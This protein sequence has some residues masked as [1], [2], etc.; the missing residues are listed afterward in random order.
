VFA[1]LAVYRLWFTS[2]KAEGYGIQEDIPEGYR[3]YTG[4]AASKLSRSDTSRAKNHDNH[5]NFDFLINLE[6]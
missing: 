1:S 4:M 3:V 6:N 2:A 5:E